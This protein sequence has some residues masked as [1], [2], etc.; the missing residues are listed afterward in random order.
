MDW[1]TFIAELLKALAWPVAVVTS[2]WLVREHLAALLR[3]LRHLRY[4]GFEAD[5]G[6]KIEEAAEA[7]ETVLPPIQSTEGGMQAKSP[8][9]RSF[10]ELAAVSPSAAVVESW[11][12]VEAALQEAAEACGVGPPSRG[13]VPKEVRDRLD[14]QT[15][16]LFQNLRTLSRHALH[17]PDTKITTA[18]AMEFRE[19]ARRLAV[20][21]KNL[22]VH[23]R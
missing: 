10:L 17:D 3:E 4:G 9:D 5:F 20:K 22:K 19:L 2:V 8:E 23:E 6:S 21:L 18:E 15:V 7:A 1:L 12:D 13:W 14:L 16:K 11:R